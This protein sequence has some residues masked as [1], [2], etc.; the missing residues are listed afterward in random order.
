MEYQA[1]M[2]P[3]LEN[4][5]GHISLNFSVEDRSKTDDAFMIEAA[6]EYMQRMGI[7]DTQYIVVRHNDRE[8][9]HCHIVFNRVGNSG[10]TIIDSN[11]RRRSVKVCRALTEKYGLYLNA[12]DAKLNVKR[13][14]LRVPDKV[15]YQIYDA[16]RAALPYCTDWD[17]LRNR[18]EKRGIVAQF[19]YKGGTQ[20]KEGVIFSKD[21]HAFSGSKIDRMFSFSKLDGALRANALNLESYS[22]AA[23]RRAAEQNPQGPTRPNENGYRENIPAGGRPDGLFVFYPGSPED[24]E[25]DRPR[26]LRKNKRGRSL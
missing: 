10:K 7:V 3:R 14:R 9:P 23:S 16:L 26:K 6:R 8:H 25:D 17:A 1:Q 13:D 22:A 15:K 18:L 12:G 24:P 21:G 4:R 11:D 19:K 5:F 20:Q 2:N